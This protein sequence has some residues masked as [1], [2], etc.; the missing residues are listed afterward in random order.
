MDLLHTNDVRHICLVCYIRC[1]TKVL[2]ENHHTCGR[3]YGC[4]EKLEE[5]IK[6]E[7]DQFNESLLEKLAEEF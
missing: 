3:P 6:W 7:L 5:I 1:D 2:K 4:R